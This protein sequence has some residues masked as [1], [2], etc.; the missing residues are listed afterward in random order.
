MEFHYYAKH[1]HAVVIETE[2]FSAMSHNNAFVS[3]VLDKQ[4]KPAPL[5]YDFCFGWGQKSAVA[6][7]E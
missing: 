2:Y 5:N 4:S 6:F 7:K 1:S 3:M